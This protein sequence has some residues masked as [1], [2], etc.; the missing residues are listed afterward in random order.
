MVLN[1][2]GK[3]LEDSAYAP[4]R[5]GSILTYISKDSITWPKQ[6]LQY[7]GMTTQSNRPSTVMASAVKILALHGQKPISLDCSFSACASFDVS[8][9]STKKYQLQ[10]KT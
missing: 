4:Q 10:W 2:I 1:N 5:S 6:V 3:A 7:S 9:K 8:S